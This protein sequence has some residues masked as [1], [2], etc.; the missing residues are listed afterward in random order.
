MS[1]PFGLFKGATKDEIKVGTEIA[2]FTYEIPSPPKPHSF[3]FIVYA[4]ITP[5]HGVSFVKAISSA[6]STSGAG[7]EI[8]SSF[9]TF[10]EKLTKV[11]GNPRFVDTFIEGGMYNKVTEWMDSIIYKGRQYFSSWHVEDGLTLP[12]DLKS[13]FLTV[14]PEDS[15][16]GFIHLEYYFNN[17]AAAEDEISALEDDAL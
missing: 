7:L 4:T 13:V 14:I 2:K 12:N 1:G 3:F 17:N 11:Y 10:T 6:I 15:Y 9:I 16:S 5:N 8:K